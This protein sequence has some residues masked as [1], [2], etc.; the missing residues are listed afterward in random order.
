[1]LDDIN[2]KIINRNGESHDIDFKKIKD[3]INLL[4]NYEDQYSQPLTNISTSMMSSI[5]NNNLMHNITEVQLDIEIAKNY[6]NYNVIHYNY[7]YLGGRILVSNHHKNLNILNLNSFSDRTNY[8]HEHLNNFFNTGYIEFISNNKEELD[9]ILDNNRDYMLSYFAFK[10]LENSYLIKVND[11]IIE[12]P[13]DMFM[14]SSISIHYRDSN[15]LKL[16]KETYENMSLGYFTHATPTLFNAGTKYEQLSSCYLLGTEDSI[17]DIFKT[18]SDSALISK[19]SGGIGIH[20]S[21]IR[22]NGS[23]IK[24]T[25]GISNGIL[26]MIKVYNEVAR[27]VNQCFVGDTLVYTKNGIKEIQNVINSDQL[28]TIDGSFKGINEIIISEIDNNILEIKTYNSLMSVKVTVEHQIYVIDNDDNDYFYNIQKKLDNGIIV[29]KFKSAKDLRIND[30]VG[31][32]IPSY[33]LDNDVYDIEFCKFFGILLNNGLGFRICVFDKNFTFIKEFLNKNNIKYIICDDN[34]NYITWDNNINIP[35]T[36]DI[37]LGCNIPNNI[38]HLP[39]RKIMIIMNFINYRDDLSTNLKMQIKYMLLKINLMPI[40]DNYIKWNNILWCKIESINEISFKGKVYDFNMID[41]HNYLT[42]IGLVHNSGKRKGAIAL[43]LEPWHVD[44]ENFLEIKKNTG[45]ETERA[46]DI[47]TALWVPDIFMEK[48]QKNEDWYLMCPSE[49]PKLTEVYGEEFNILYNT[50]I[51]EKKYKKIVKSQE[52]FNKIIDSQIETGIPYI[53]YKDNINRK[54]NQSNIG[55]IKSSNLCAEIVEV[56]NKNEYA[57]CNLASIAV[58][59]FIKINLEDIKDIN[60][61]DNFHEKIKLIYD[62][63]KLLHISKI[64]TLNLNNIIDYNYYPVIEAHNSNM[65]NRPIGIGIQGL[66]DLYYILN[67]PYNSYESKYLDA[68]IMETIYYGSIYMSSDISKIKG[69]YST[70]KDSPFSLQQL[71]FD[72]WEKENKFNFKKLYPQMH[73][74]DS[75]KIKIKSD[76][77]YNSMLTAL[78]PTATSASIMGNNESFEPLTSCLFKRTTSAGEFQIVNKYLIQQLIDLNMWNTEI[79]ESI[80]K[81]NGSIQHL[82]LDDMIKNTYKTI[83]EIK[84]KDIIDHALARAPYIDQSQSMNLYFSEPN[85]N[86]I[87]SALMYGWE[88]GIKTGIYYLRTSTAS[89]AT[90][91]NLN[92]VMCSS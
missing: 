58:N 78:M 1:M 55:I 92:C 11:S 79:I 84:Q 83:W 85:Y 52:L 70:Y 61:F 34:I 48:V 82:Q 43:Y 38:L 73:D 90:K 23:H 76:G 8:I 60:L 51:S 14:R 15:S 19:W 5:I 66:S 63:D 75:L 26:P 47:F 57:V 12:T 22:G 62:F 32:P 25:N 10:T 4:I 41:N 20:I 35:I 13:Q 64:I 72:L 87:Y 69:S 2:M 6:E 29:P 65:K 30:L 71:Q 68:L 49:C 59:K 31:Y 37:L 86:N 88:K 40:H 7:G 33:E 80:D 77:M 89:S 28:I 9:I 24:S 36:N 54:N 67:L 17:E 27:Y 16:I 56:S 3:R 42:D 44:I 21:N 74:W 81:K 45:S 53:L 46:R 50:Y 18:I 39:I 91:V